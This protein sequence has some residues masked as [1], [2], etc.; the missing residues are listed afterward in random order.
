VNWTVYNN[1]NS[2]LPN[3]TVKAIAIDGQGNKWIGTNSG[4]AK[5]DGVNWTV[6]NNSNSGLPDNNVLAIAI[7]GQGNKWIGTGGGLQSLME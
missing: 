6:Y 3:N 1:S 5:F 7:D 4:L 2:G